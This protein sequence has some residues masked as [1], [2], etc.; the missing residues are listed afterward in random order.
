MKKDTTGT[1]NSIQALRAFAALAVVYYHIALL[2]LGKTLQLPET[3]SWG[4]DVFFIISGFIIGMVVNQNT[5]NFL[6]RRVIR[7]VPLYWLATFAWAGLALAFPGKV[8]STEVTF[9]GLLKSLFFIPYEMPQRVGPILGLGWTLNYEMFFYLMVALMLFLM[10]DAR[11]ALS[12]T[13]ITL[14]LLV[15]SGNVYTPTNFAL[16]HYQNP[17]LLEFVSGV[18]LYFT[19]RWCQQQAWIKRFQPLTIC[20][21][22]I[23]FTGGTYLL[24]AQESGQLG[25][26]FSQRVGFFGVPAFLTVTGTLLLEPLF[27]PSKLTSAVVELGAGSY[28]IYLFHPFIVGLLGPSFLSNKIGENQIALGYAIVMAVLLMSAV[29][30]TGINRYLDAPIQRKLKKLLR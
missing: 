1:I 12:L 19:Y 17:L 27:K 25:Y 2:P 6:P 10:K 20:C 23:L 9:L 3:G 30:G 24:V 29:V 18:F 28:A 13:V 8:N 15:A 26:L 21:G 22:I 14:V 16:L 5:T 4:V 11:K 7:V